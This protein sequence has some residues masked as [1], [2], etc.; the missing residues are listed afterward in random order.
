MLGSKTNTVHV[1]DFGLSISYLDSYG[2][3]IKPGYL[4]QHV[5]TTRYMSVSAHEAKVQCRKNDLESVGYMLLYFL[6]GKLPWSGQKVAN[7]KELNRVVCDIKQRT[8]LEELCLGHPPEFLKYL[9]YAQSL[10]FYD[11]PDYDN[12]R[13][14]FKVMFNKQGLKDDGVYDWNR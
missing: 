11:N 2:K 8:P 7:E 1:I 9:K 12:M 13:R 5:G 6:R 10:D 3:H 4:G 14:W